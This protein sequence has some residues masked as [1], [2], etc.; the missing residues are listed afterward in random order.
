MTLALW[1]AACS[2]AQAQSNSRNESWAATKH[3]SRDNTNPSRTTESHATF[4]NRRVDRR[5]TEVIGPDGRYQPYLEVEKET[6][7][8]S[9]SAKRTVVRT[10]G[11][12]VNG[13]RSLAQVTEEEARSSAS[14]DAQVVRTT[15]NPDANGNLQV[16]QREVAETRKTGAD[17]QET[18]TTLY[19]ADGNSGFSPSLQTRELQKRSADRGLEVTKTTLVPDLDGNW[20]VGEVKE[21]TIKEEGTNRLSEERIARPDLEGRL[22]EVSRTVGKETENAA[23]EKSNTIE[24]YSVD[25]AGL[26]RDGSM[27]LKGRAST[28]QKKASGAQ[29]TDEQ[30]EE[31]NPGNPSDA[32]QVTTKSTDVVRSRP[33]GTQQT[34]TVQGRDV[35][36]AYNVIAVETRKSDRTSATQS[37]TAPSDKPK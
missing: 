23:G 4:G 5:I 16:V 8:V 27:H 25:V 35:N 14:G 13:Q 30:F 37:Q 32:F 11:W 15:S 3:F 28:I 31:P 29:A 18:K 17:V 10:Y 33:S 7:D 21:S 26:A 34:Q 6:I 22:S 19:L 12:D 9:A 1:W 2:H 20:K 24:T 36:G